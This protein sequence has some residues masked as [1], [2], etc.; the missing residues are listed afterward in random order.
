MKLHIKKYIKVL[1]DQYKKGVISKY[2]FNKELEYIKKTIKTSENNQ[3][4]Q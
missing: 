3:V 1:N 2:I 4:A